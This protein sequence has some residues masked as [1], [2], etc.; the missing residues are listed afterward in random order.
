MVN[1]VNNIIYNTL[2]VERAVHLPGVGTLSVVRKSAELASGGM[3]L[4]PSYT[5]EFSSSAYATSLVDVIAREAGVDGTSAEDIYSRWL[6]KVRIESTL[7]I[8]GVGILRYK[9]FVADGEF[10][11]QLTPTTAPIK[12]KRHNK[13]SATVIA[14]IST[15]IGV[16]VVFGAAAWFFFKD[17]K[18]VDQKTAEQQNTIASNVA[19]VEETIVIEKV[20]EEVVPEETI[21]VAEPETSEVVDDWTQSGDIRHWV[22]A[23]SYST[24]QNA[25]IA[26]D[27]LITKHE[28]VQCDIFTL[29]KM[30][31]VAVYGSADREDCV[32]F[33][34]EHG[35]EIENMWIFTP[36]KYQ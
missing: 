9:S 8:E 34:R 5:V 29:G 25:N 12:I 16:G 33:M 10:M 21:E 4:P 17:T 7:T 14:L 27:A 2:V 28:G 35:H 3:V 20:I 18:E 26:K 31:A 24:E 13:G 36:K 22:V 23:G 32:Q 19:E 6:D 11:T 15:F 30:Y 1:E